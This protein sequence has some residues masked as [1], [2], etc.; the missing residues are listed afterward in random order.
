MFEDDRRFK[1]INENL[2]QII[3]FR[4]K[5][6][7]LVTPSCFI[8]NK[9]YHYAYEPVDTEYSKQ[10]PPQS[11]N[12]EEEEKKEEEDNPY[13]DEGGSNIKPKRRLT[14]KRKHKKTRKNK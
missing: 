7:N 11:L 10:G 14:K 5:N 1:I 4:D 8:F 2:P 13:A 9:K 12:I 6:I 3:F